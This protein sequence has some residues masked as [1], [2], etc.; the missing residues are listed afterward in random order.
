MPL[1][2]A[3]EYRCEASVYPPG[4]TLAIL[5]G[6]GMPLMFATM[7]IHPVVAVVVL[8][9]SMFAMMKFITGPALFTIDEQGITREL[10]TT[11]GFSKDRKPRI[12]HFGWDKLQWFKE[13]RD[14]G[15]FSA[16]YQYVTVHFKNGTEWMI[17][18]N[19]GV[20]KAEFEVFRTEFLA[21]VNGYN[22]RVA[23][24]P[25]HTEAT[26][27][28]VPETATAPPIQQRRTFYETVWAK[29]FTV[30]LGALIVFFIF[31]MLTTNYVG[32]TSIFKIFV[33]LI[34]GFGYMWYRVFREKK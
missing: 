14:R 9:G 33:I 12:E 2:E 22:Q 20:R 8:V 28:V 23:P 13:G 10:N 21:L 5:T 19:N 4:M 1:N 32:L 6:V 34:P 31:L 29:V 15:R 26:V 3:H 24:A 30:A 11:L 27:P 25:V 7:F 16:E 17:T 18:D